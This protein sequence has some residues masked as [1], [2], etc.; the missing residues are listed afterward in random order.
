[1]LRNAPSA[2]GGELNRLRRRNHLVTLGFA[3]V[4]FS[5]DTLLSYLG[6]N[7]Y[8]GDLWLRLA[9]IAFA[10]GMLVRLLW[11]GRTGHAVD[12]WETV[13]LVV[14]TLGSGLHLGLSAYAQ[15]LTPAVLLDNGMWLLILYLYTFSILDGRRA[16]AWNFSV[17]ALISFALIPLLPAA[18][19]SHRWS[20]LHY[21]VIALMATVV[22]WGL[23]G[24]RMAYA[25]AH[26]RVVEAEHESLTDSLTNQPNRRA[27]RFTLAREI[28]RARRTVRPFALLVLD[29]DHFKVLNDTYGHAVGDAVLRELAAVIRSGLREGDEFGRWGGEE[30]VVIAPETDEA[31]AMLLAERL[32]QALHEHDWPFTRVRASFGITISVPGDT[33]EAIFDRADVALYRAKEAGRDRSEVVLAGHEGLPA[34]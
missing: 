14:L 32:R 15:G 18:T 9:L 2:V 24:W 25:D 28:A 30:F 13:A 21:Q 7:G 22:G 20:F 1:M 6:G 16:L 34:A 5:G 8:A 4:A 17:L 19:V 10:V 26:R 3:A 29:L 27:L 31:E 11:R 33:I 12:G 23:A